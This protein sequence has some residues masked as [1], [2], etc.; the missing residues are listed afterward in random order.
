MSSVLLNRLHLRDRERRRLCGR[1]VWGAALEN[2]RVR[3][4]IPLFTVVQYFNSS[5][6]LVM[7]NG[8]T[9]Y[10]FLIS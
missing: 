6:T 3:V 7:A 8:F 5:I 2:R 1:V 9:L 10:Q 4:Q